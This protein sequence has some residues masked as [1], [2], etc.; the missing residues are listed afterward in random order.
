MLEKTYEA[1][2]GQ[3]TAMGAEVFEV[4]ALR[5]SNG[6]KPDFMVLREWDKQAVMESI[7]WLW[8]QNWHGSHI[9]VRPKGESNLTLVDDLKYHGVARLRRA[10]LQPAAVVQTSPGNYQVWIKHTAQLDK[11]LGT[12]VARELAERFGGDAKAAAW[13][14]FGRLSGFRN[15]K[16]K[17]QEVVP[18]PEY[19]EWR[20]KRFH[21]NLEGQWVDRKVACTLK[22]G[23]ARCT[24]VSYRPPDIH[25]CT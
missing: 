23:F 16:T 24:R 11:E 9:Y 21:R 19:D 1:V 22:R 25:S 14:H 12:A 7:P 2:D 4:G 15:T 3:L 20:G 18:V 8:R 17:H 13:R 10:G 6:G 5:L